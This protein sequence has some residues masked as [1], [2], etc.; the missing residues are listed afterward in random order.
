MFVNNTNLSEDNFTNLLTAYPW[1]ETY[2]IDYSLFIPILFKITVK[3]EELSFY[4]TSEEK[5][6][7]LNINKPEEISAKLLELNIKESDLESL[8]K[9]QFDLIRIHASYLNEPKDYCSYTI[10]LK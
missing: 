8:V 1:I 9:A 5:Y 7:F 3:D 2:H 10:K 6:E 4:I